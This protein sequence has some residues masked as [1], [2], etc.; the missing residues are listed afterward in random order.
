MFLPLIFLIFISKI[1]NDGTGIF[2]QKR[3]GKNGIL[4]TIYKLQTFCLKTNKINKVGYFLRK[5]ELDL[6]A[7]NMVN[8]KNVKDDTTAFYRFKEKIIYQPR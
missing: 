7:P 3:F 4:F 2:K 5:Y 8:E 1:Y 6:I